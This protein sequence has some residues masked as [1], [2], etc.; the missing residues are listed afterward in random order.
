MVRNLIAIAVIIGVVFVAQQYAQPIQKK[1]VETFQLSGQPK[2]LG[3]KTKQASESGV[4]DNVKKQTMQIKIG[5]IINTVSKTV[6]AVQTGIQ[7]IRK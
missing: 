4:I 2:V 1:V 6:T 3:D 7:E 5:D